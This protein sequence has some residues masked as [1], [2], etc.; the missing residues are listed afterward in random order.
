[1][2]WRVE[3]V[4]KNW[5]DFEQVGTSDA[6]NPDISTHDQVISCFMIPP[7]QVS[8]FLDFV[9][10]SGK[11]E[12]LGEFPFSRSVDT[13]FCCIYMMVHL[14]TVLSISRFIN[15]VVILKI[16]LIC[17]WHVVIITMQEFIWVFINNPSLYTQG[18]GFRTELIS[19]LLDMKPRFLRFPGTP[20]SVLIGNQVLGH[21]W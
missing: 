19:M 21:I 16:K 7:R 2:L 15:I 6:S 9:W 18:H 10:H 1:M 11:P 14:F 8:W 4:C 12:A 5:E 17:L 13:L 20:P 3:G